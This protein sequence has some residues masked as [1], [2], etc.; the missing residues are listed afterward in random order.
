MA[1]PT[2]S[3]ILLTLALDLT[4]WRRHDKAYW[5]QVLTSAV[6]SAAPDLMQVESY[7]VHDTLIYVRARANRPAKLVR[8]LVEDHEHFLRLRARLADLGALPEF[9]I[10][11]DDR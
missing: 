8:R 2:G 4:H 3:R 6:D 1:P 9:E 7:E 10:E 11:E 5:V